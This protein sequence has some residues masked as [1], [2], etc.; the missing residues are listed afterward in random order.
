MDAWAGRQFAEINVDVAFLGT[1]EFS[2]PRGFTTPDPDEIEVKR[3]MT[4]AARRRI[5]LADHSKYG[6][7]SRCA[8][9]MASTS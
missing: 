6:R 5:L 4:A 2:A 9:P 7:L 3:L 1:Y 8:G